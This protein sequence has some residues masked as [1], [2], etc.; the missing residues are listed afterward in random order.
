M[1]TYLST[2]ISG[3]DKFISKKLSQDISDLKILKILDG[4]IL[5]E[6]NF[7][8]EQIKKIRYLNNSFL[9]L[10]KFEL[11]KGSSTILNRMLEATIKNSKII[12]QKNLNLGSKKTF[13]IFTSLENNLVSVDFNLLEK[14]EKIISKNLGLKKNIRRP[15]YEFWYLY[16]SEKIG[17]FM[18]RITHQKSKLE[19]GELRSELANILCWL[20]EPKAEDVVLDPFAGSGAIPI[21]RAKIEKFKGI[22]ALDKNE[23]IA[24]KLKNK[25][26]KIRNKKIQK[27]FFV[28]G[29]DFFEVGFDDGF[30]DSIITDPPWGFFEKVEGGVKKLYGKIL[31]KSWRVLKAGG[32]LVLLTAR[33]GEFEKCVEDFN[34][35]QI[36][37][38]YNILVSGKKVGVY[39][40]LKSL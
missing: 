1:N 40:L 11:G 33:K 37:E 8:I 14:I 23:I 9:V 2:F 15:D 32:R 6:T 13:R 12:S 28:K 19:R 5:Y 34:Q 22:F 18:F 39:V 17:F 26:K 16:R 4:A 3:F 30:F 29:K 10:E 36:L 38:K 25:I 7:E 27:S 35:F 31:E 20:S 21:E 24:K